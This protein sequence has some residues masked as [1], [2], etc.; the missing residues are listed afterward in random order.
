MKELSNYEYLQSISLE[1]FHATLCSL[2]GIPLGDTDKERVLLNWLLAKEQFTSR[3][4]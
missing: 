4:D 2:I 1:L 3:D